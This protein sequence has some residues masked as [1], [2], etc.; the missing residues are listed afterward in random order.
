M[1][2]EQDIDQGRDW[3]LDDTATSVYDRAQEDEEDGSKEEE[4]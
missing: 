2:R 4:T 1:S 3:D